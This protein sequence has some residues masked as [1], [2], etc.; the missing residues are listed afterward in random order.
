MPATSRQL[1]AVKPRKPTIKQDGSKL[2]TSGDV[3]AADA[4]APSITASTTAL[5][6][7]PL[8][9]PGLFGVVLVN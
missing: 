3:T 9:R 5:N 6:D 8:S 7:K 2:S 1:P 4:A